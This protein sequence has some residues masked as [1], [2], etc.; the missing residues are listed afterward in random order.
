MLHKAERRTTTTKVVK[1]TEAEAV[2]FVVGKTVGLKAG[3]ASAGLHPALPR[4]RFASGES[5]EVIQQTSA[6]ILAALQP[7][8]EE[9]AAMP[10]AELAKVRNEDH[11]SN[12]HNGRRWHHGLNLKDR[13]PA[14]YGVG[15]RVHRRVRPMRTPCY[16]CRSLRR[17]E[18]R[19]NARPGDVFRAWAWRRA[20]LNPFYW[21]N[22]YAGIEQ[23]SRFIQDSQY[24]FHAEL[25]KQHEQFAKQWD[26]NLREQGF[27]EAFERQK[28]NPRA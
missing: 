5:L 19:P 20:H 17:T 13:E 3:T 26:K 21:R 23:W 28:R 16:F 11:P 10:D 8:T 15:D 7:P 4:Q 18:W 12:P 1:E 25:Y 14:L 2:A 27:M 22:D 6:V 24:A 9:Q